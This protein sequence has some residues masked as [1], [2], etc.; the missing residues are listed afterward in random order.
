MALPDYTKPLDADF[1]ATS[2]GDIRDNWVAPSVRVHSTSAIIVQASSTLTLTYT[3]ER[4]DTA[5][6]WSSTASSRLIATV[7]GKYS[8]IANV[9]WPSNADGY[10]ALA[11]RRNGVTDIGGVHAAPPTGTVMDMQVFSVAN[12]SANDYVE[13]LATQTSTSSLAIAVSSQ[14]SPE[15]MMTLVSATT[16]I[17]T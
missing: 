12:M 14:I 10:R 3:A 15:F 17:S 4:W 1:I 13:V 16:A 5:G 7:A 2:A 6:S 9:R 8:I 11:I